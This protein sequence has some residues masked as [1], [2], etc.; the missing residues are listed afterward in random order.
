MSGEDNEVKTFICNVSGGTGGVGGV[1]GM[2]GGGGGTGQGPTVNYHINVVGNLINN[3]GGTHVVHSDRLKEDLSKWLESPPDTKDRQH[4]LRKL[5]HEST[6]GWLL[7]DVRFIKWKAT[8]GSLWIKGIS[9]TGKSVL[10]STVI[11]EITMACPKQS[12][13]AYFYFDFRNERQHM[14]IM[15][16]SIILQLSRRSPLPYSAL[17]QLYKTLGHGTIQPQH[18]HLQGVLK[19]L[20]SEL[21]QTYIVIDGLDECNKTD[22]KNLIK[23]IRSLCHPVKNALH[24]LFTSQPFEEFKTAFKDVTFIEL[25]SKVSTDD[26]RS[27]IGSEVRMARNWASDDNCAKDVTEQIVQKSN[28][29][30]RF[31]MAACLLIE[32]GRCHWKDNWEEAFIAFPTDLFGIYSRFLTQATASL[33]TVFIEAIFR[34]LVFSARPV[35]PD[36]LADAIAFRLDDPAFDFSDLAKSS[37]RP[38][39]RRGNSDSFKL[40]EGLIVVKD[41]HWAEPSITLA[42]SSVRDYILSPQFHQEFGSIIDLTKGVSHRFI[43]QTCVHYILHFADAKHLITKDTLPDYPIALYA[44]RYWFY[45]LQFCN[46]QDQE[47]LLPATMHLLEDGSSQHA[48]VYKLCPRRWHATCAWDGPISP[49]VCM[50]SDMGYTA[51]VRFL[52][53]KHNASVNQATKEG[54]TVLHFASEKGHLDIARLLIE[55]NAS[56]DLATKDGKTALHFASWNGHIDIARLL[57]KHNASIDLVTKAGETALHLA[58]EK[59]HLDIAHWLIKHNASFDLATKSGS[60]GLHLASENGH[61]NIVRLL[62]K[63]NAS[64]DLVTKDGETALHLALE[65]GHLN[66]AQLLIKHN[67]SVDQAT[68]EGKTALH[69]AS[70]NGHLNIVRLLIE[71]NA[72]IDL[73]TEDDKTALHFASWNGHLDIVRLLIEYNA[74]VD[75]MAN[76]GWIDQGKTALHF[77]LEKGHVD[78]AQLLIK[79]NASVDLAT[80][81]GKTALHLA[82]EEGHLDIVQLLIKHNG[83]VNLATKYGWTALHFASQNGHFDIV[84]LLIEYNTPVELAIKDGWIDKGK[85]ALHLASEKGHLD[86]VKLLIKHNVSV[87]LATNDGKTALH[88]ALEED[89]LNIVQLLIKHNASVNLATKYGWTALHLASQKGHLDIARLLIEHNAFVDLVTKDGETALHLALE[90]GHLNIVHLLIKCQASVSFQR[91]ASKPSEHYCT[92]AIPE[93]ES[94]R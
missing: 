32:L 18:V 60:T 21:D 24:L 61:L 31:R 56:I 46:D 71:H 58:S 9:G 80:S 69:F 26:I 11:E 25:G 45:H 57:V 79:H 36:E 66:I 2:T 73:A 48:A 52:L 7:H 81:D 47:A 20:L 85:T 67:G 74:L 1:G 89:H 49:A 70:E 83:S 59:G 30:S 8:P 65:E 50:C 27:F 68:K 4:D 82:L 10:S 17:H 29:M 42:H 13:V 63:H 92:S 39:R 33:K 16:R 62:I 76:D 28:G 54:K 38:D 12:A 86:I 91:T 41:E 94:S 37:Y 90:N 40:L 19:D 15:L 72:S 43:T 44:A 87:D 55:H 5:H 34:W 64:V 75:L 3:S 77:A 88:L 6:G 78:I 35:R 51:G 84:R 14:D 22:W 23:F 93:V 53:I